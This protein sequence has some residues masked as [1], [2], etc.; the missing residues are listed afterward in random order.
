MR[1]FISGTQFVRNTGDE[2]RWEVP[3]TV[4]KCL[5][6]L[7]L[8]ESDILIGDCAGIDNRVQ[9]YL[10]NKK[11][12]N[13]TVYVSGSKGF[14]RNNI[15][16]WMEKHFRAQGQ[17][18]YSY[19]IEKDFRM[20]EDAESGIAIWDGESKGTFINILYLA[21][22]GKKSKVYLIP[23]DR[24]I[25]IDSVDDLEQ[26]AGK[27]GII[28]SGEKKEI[29]TRCG[30]SD[31]MIDFHT[32]KNLMS[33]Y[34]LAEIICG[35][36]V[37][38]DAKLYMLGIMGRK[39][40]IKREV[41]DSV[42]ENIRHGKPLKLVKHDIR[43]IV[44]YRSKDT[45][46]THLWKLHDEIMEAKNAMF[47]PVGT[48]L[49]DKPLYLFSE[50]Y[51]TED[52]YHKSSPCGLFIMPELV[53]KYIENEEKEN[54]TG[55]GYYCMEVWDDYDINHDT[56]RY[57]YYFYDGEWCWFEKL[58]PKK[59]DNGNKY[60]MPESRRFTSG[61]LDLSIET[62]YQPGDI[63][64]IDC[65]PFGPVFYAMI[66][67]ARDQYVCC[68]PTIL[69]K[70][71]GTDA[72]K[73]VAL[74]HRMFYKDIEMGTYE[75]MLSPLYRIRRVTMDDFSYENLTDDVIML[76]TLSEEIAGEEENAERVWRNCYSLGYD[77]M[78]QDEILNLF[79]I[80]PDSEGDTL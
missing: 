31:E 57:D 61:D 1:I 38:L 77:Y 76:F 27:E 5:D 63:V 33:P 37:S 34:V 56:E 68:F 24:W 6:E 7:I 70:V 51:D 19:R 48:P 36:P 58:I 60:Y 72:W 26:Y 35:A 52:L 50:W 13:V 66:L 21:A 15:G 75:P 10:S 45:I 18:A 80:P 12:D 22:Q 59:Q 65:R 41:Y 44:E 64:Y 69:F 32:S 67:N 78:S 30:F 4:K 54:D 23:K 25:N 2:K 16:K 49:H 55:E 62:P 53:K 29:M 11:Y 20:A 43:A 42:L 28:G 74:K 40:N 46:W 73:I 39:R 71:P 14:T 3:E 79:Y 8:S 47:E 9:E 17:T